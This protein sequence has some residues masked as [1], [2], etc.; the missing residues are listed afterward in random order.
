MNPLTKLFNGDEGVYLVYSTWDSFSAKVHSN[1]VKNTNEEYLID[2]FE[3]PEISSV[4]WLP[5]KV[6]RVPALIFC[7]KQSNGFV[8]YKL[9]D[10]PS[11]VGR[12]VEKINSLGQVGD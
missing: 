12:A 6:N 2:T 7:S 9:M 8:K 11:Q 4:P 10:I 3:H 5:F 1:F